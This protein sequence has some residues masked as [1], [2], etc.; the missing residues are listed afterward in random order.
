MAV[1]HTSLQF[2]WRK[3]LQYCVEQASELEWDAPLLQR[4]PSDGDKWPWPAWE[5][6]DMCEQR[7]NREI[8]KPASCILTINSY[9]IYSFLFW[10]HTD[11][12]RHIHPFHHT[13]WLMWIESGLTYSHSGSIPGWTWIKSLGS[14]PPC[15]VSLIPIH[16]G[17]NKWRRV[18][19]LGKQ[20][21]EATLGVWSDK[22]ISME[23]L[24]ARGEDTNYGKAKGEMG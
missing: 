22:A 20:T 4:T 8:G 14:N 1:R 15:A 18:N 7:G 19:R 13:D 16:S 21:I 17:Y 9:N 3:M 2:V 6:R 12:N 10:T 11:T 23:L 5:L 24:G